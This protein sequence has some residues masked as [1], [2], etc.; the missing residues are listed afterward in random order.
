MAPIW[1][2]YYRGVKKILFVIDGPNIMQLGTATLS[3][4]NMVNHPHL[5]NAEVNIFSILKKITSLC[6]C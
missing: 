4:L 1:H 2:N 6:T 3:F 5:R